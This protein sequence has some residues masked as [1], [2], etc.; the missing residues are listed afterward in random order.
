[1]KPY[2]PLTILHA[3][4]HGPSLDLAAIRFAT[5]LGADSIGWT[6]AYRRVPALR[7]RIRYRTRVGNPNG[8]PGAS[9]RGACDVPIMVHRGRRLLDWWAFKACDA[10]EPLRIAPDRWLTGVIYEHP[11]GEVEHIDAHP[12][13]AVQGRPLDLDRVRQYARQMRRLES[14]I[15]RAQRAGRI[16]IVSGD[17]NWSLGSDL[18]PLFAPRRLFERLDLHWWREGIDWIAYSPHL[19]LVTRDVHGPTLTGSDHPWMLARFAL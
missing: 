2:D 5:S 7:R 14:R 6:E 3:P 4:C 16:V 19:R 1:M 9:I 17:L 12:N 18:D 10:S 8:I 15:L 11:F 13:A